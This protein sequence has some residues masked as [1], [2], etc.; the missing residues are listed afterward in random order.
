MSRPGSVA[1]FGSRGSVSSLRLAAAAKKAAL[2]AEVEH[3]K[4]LNALEMEELRLQQRHQDLEWKK[5]LAVTEAEEKAL[6]D[7]GIMEEEVPDFDALLSIEYAQNQRTDRSQS[8]VASD[9]SYQEDC[10]ANCTGEG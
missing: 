9:K 4:E 7:E 5:K 8:G 10:T 6:S 3:Q 1:S 2:L